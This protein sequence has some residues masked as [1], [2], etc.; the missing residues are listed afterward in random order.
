MKYKCIKCGFIH[1][2]ELPDGYFCPLCMSNHSYFELIYEEE[3]VYNRVNIDNDNCCINRILEKCIN[4]GACSRTCENIVGIKYDKSKCNGICIN[5]GQCILTCPTGALTPKYDY[6]TVMDFIKDP[7]YRV[8]VLTSPACR[9]SLGDAFG[10]EHGK[11]VEGKMVAALKKLGF[12]YVFDTTFGADMTSVEEAHELKERLSENRLPMFSS[13]CPSWVKYASIYHP[14]LLDSLS[15]VKSPIGMASTAIMELF[16]PNE[17]INTE[18]LIFV[19]L[20]PCTIKKDEIIGTNTDYVI[21]TSE[22]ALMIR[23]NNINFNDLK[24]ENF[25]KVKGSTAGTIF[26]T[27]AG[28][29]ISVLRCLYHEITGKDLKDS[30]VLIE[31]KEYYKQI[32]VKINDRIVKCII[33]STMPNLE[34]LLKEQIDADFIEVMNCNGGCI[35]GGGQILMPVKD[36]ELIKNARSNSLNNKDKYSKIKYPYNNELIEDLYN[37]YLDYPGSSKACQYLHTKHINKSYLLNNK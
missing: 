6:Q 18:K 10:L 3:K 25:D 5:C 2:G 21:T 20:T 19:A 15:S 27:S 16:G 23:E 1:E 22:L 33:V 29:T 35:S 12:D 7:D 36:R 11:F 26:G 34:R 30:Q 24:D 32:K 31:D 4:C 9:V 13:C 14:E 28:V 17:G 8:A 37:T